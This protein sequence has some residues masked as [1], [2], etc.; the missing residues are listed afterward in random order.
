VPDLLQFFHHIKSLIDFTQL[1]KDKK[2][3]V[4]YSEGK[5]YWV[6]L[7]GLVREVLE[8]SDVQV[9]YISSGADDPGLA[10][11][12]SN[13][14][15][16]DIDEGFVR[17]WL[18]ENMDAGVLVMSMPDL[19]QYQV[20]RSKFGV[21]YVYVQHSLVSFHMVYREGAFDHF[22]TIFCAGPHHLKEARALEAQYNL[23]E[24]NLVNHG[25]AR[26]DAIIDEA[27]KRPQQEKRKEDPTHV[28]FAPSWGPDSTIESGFGE[29]IVTQLLADG[30]RVTFRP[31]P[32]T[33]KFAGG[34]V[35]TI[36]Q[37][38]KDNDLFCFEDNVAGQT[39]LHASDIMICD[40]SGAAL[41]YAFGL[42]KPVLF[43]DVPRKVNNPRYAEIDIEPLEVGIRQ[44]VGDVLPIE[45]IS[46]CSE[47]VAALASAKP[48]YDASDFVFN[49]G[50]SNEAGFHALMKLVDSD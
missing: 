45:S 46:K 36:V 24:K 16:F 28:L 49:L 30:F 40:W 33:T 14:R 3:L 35:R 4:F 42:N 12:H 9:C 32:Q 38:H 2:Q 25:Y 20:K 23:P 29:E 8:N 27:S 1:P 41:E 22:D 17:N 50:K 5:N 13:Y 18:F 39:S 48:V 11:K 7:E 43:V 26:L 34:R 10:L 37:A 15:T 44:L 31:H 19:H 21:H 6:H 47:R